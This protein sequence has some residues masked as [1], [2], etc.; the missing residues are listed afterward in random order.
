MS[1]PA[2]DLPHS[3]KPTTVRRFGPLGC[4]LMSMV[5]LVMLVGALLYSW[6]AAGMRR[7]EREL[8]SIRERGQPA[9]ADDM[10]AFYETPAASQDCTRIWI[11]ALQPL[12]GPAYI[13]AA[14]KLPIVGMGPEIPP[15]GTSW[16][17]QAAVE[18]FL[19]QYKSSMEQLHEAADRGGAARFDLD[20]HDGISMLL[21]HVQ[22]AR[23]GARMLALEAQVRAHRGDAAGAADSLDAMFKLGVSLENEPI[24]ISQLVKLA[25]DGVARE[26]LQSLL[27]HVEFADED[28]QRLQANLRHIDYDRALHRALLGERVCGVV[29]FN[30]PG[31]FGGGNLAWKITQGEDLA[32]YLTFM[33]R[34]ADAAEQP[35]PTVQDEAAAVN[36]EVKSLLGGGLARF[37]YTMTAN[38]LPAINAAVTAAARGGSQN[39]AADAA[40]A[41]ELFRRRHGR[42]PADLNELAP[43][44]LPEVPLDRI[45]GRPLRF[46]VR[47]GECAI[48]SVGENG[49]DDGGSIDFVTGAG[50]PADWGFRLSIP[51][52]GEGA[53]EE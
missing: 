16:P 14:E 45:D 33:G 10:N 31:E 35:W 12:E 48:Y 32:T 46:V 7:A 50:A 43:E 17:Q 39:D 20:F 26:Q 22:A 44:F 2:A 4:L 27:P 52:A 13:L 9:S 38:L 15:P 8:A 30:Y 11:A 41:V 6:R 19:E 18:Q 53:S 34:M 1:A 5:A 21:G 49:V 47:D 40:L 24:L 51:A 28:L 3:A 29:A 23:G 25:L 36:D 42:L 37:R